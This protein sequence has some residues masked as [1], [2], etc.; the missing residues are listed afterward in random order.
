MLKST[1]TAYIQLLFCFSFG[2][3]NRFDEEFPQALYAKVSRSL[4]MATIPL[5]EVV[6]SS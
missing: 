6:L 2:L 4:N 1:N 3:S 5:C